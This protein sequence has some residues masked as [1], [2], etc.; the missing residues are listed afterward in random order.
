MRLLDFFIRLSLQG[1]NTAAQLRAI[2]AAATKARKELDGVGAATKRANRAATQSKKGFL[3]TA[4]RSVRLGGGARIGQS[5]FLGAELA[6]GTLMSALTRLPPPLMA[7]AAAAGAAAVAVGALARLDKARAKQ[8]IGIGAASVGATKAQMAQLAAQQREGLFKAGSKGQNV[9]GSVG[10]TDIAEMQGELLKAGVTIDDVLNGKLLGALAT[11]RVADPDVPIENLIQAVAN[12][13]PVAEAT[14]QTIDQAAYALSALAS[15]T[16]FSMQEVSTAIA[17][18]APNARSAGVSINELSQLMMLG[19]EG[20]ASAAREAQALR[21]IITKID[22]TPFTKLASGEKLALFEQRMGLSFQTAQ[23][24]TRSIFEIGEQ[25]RGLQGKLTEVQFSEYLTKRFQKEGR[26]FWLAFLN[27]SPKDIEAARVKAG[28]G[29][30]VAAIAAEIG[31][32][33]SMAKLE[34]VKNKGLKFLEVLRD[35]GLGTLF[36]FILD[37]L[38][39][40][41]DIITPILGAIGHVTR[42]IIDGITGLVRIFGDGLVNMVKPLY[43]LLPDSAKKFLKGLAGPSGAFGGLAATLDAKNA[44][45]PEQRTA[46]VAKQAD[47]ASKTKTVQDNVLSQAADVKKIAEEASQKAS[48]FEPLLRAAEVFARGMTAFTKAARF[49][50]Q[51]E[52]LLMLAD[53]YNMAAQFMRAGQV[54]GQSFNMGMQNGFALAGAGVGGVT[55][56][57]DNRQVHGAS[58]HEVTRLSTQVANKVQ[59]KQVRRVEGKR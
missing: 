28:Q 55:N 3:A 20:F 5:G 29:E 17:T 10:M 59:A 9:L 54:L 21:S 15:G 6:P 58:S 32:E 53:I 1:G 4:L 14:G 7:L 35:A 26:Q 27:Q 16:K 24:T 22:I 8:A 51:A 48:A 45:T 42:F 11:L 25:L 57:Y 49:G 19:E 44:K 40:L 37:A 38:G 23:G 34:G 39:A 30:N 47:L 50:V 56:Y 2:T 31:S 41:L 46:A 52:L 43:N 33:T 13:G 36:N 18:V 12:A